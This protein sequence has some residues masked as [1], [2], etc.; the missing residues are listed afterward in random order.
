MQPTMEKYVDL[1]PMILKLVSPECGAILPH[2]V[3]Q[4]MFARLYT[5]PDQPKGILTWMYSLFSNS[6]VCSAREAADVQGIL[7]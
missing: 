2:F 1:L 5:H 7:H 3:C 4:Q 6:L